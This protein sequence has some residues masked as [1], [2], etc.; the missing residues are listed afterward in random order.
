MKRLLPLFALLLFA[1]C[2]AFSE[3]LP[4][5]S[6]EEEAEEEPPDY[7]YDLFVKDIHSVPDYPRLTEEYK[8]RVQVQRY[9][10]YQPSGYTIWV[11]DGNQT[12]MRQNISDPELLQHFEFEYYA[13]STQPHNMRAEVL[14]LDPEHPEPGENLENNI[15]RKDVKAYPIGYYDIYNWKVNWFYDFV[16][17]QVRQAQAF[18]PQ[19][20]LNVSRIG[21]YVQARVPPSPGSKLFISLHEKPN[22]WGNLGVGEELAR[23]EID[24]TQ[25][26]QDASW[27]W[28]EFNKTELRNDTYWIMLSYESPS[29]AGIEWYRAEGNP[30]GTV[31]DT[32]MLDLGGYGEWEY[33]GFDFAF[34]V[35]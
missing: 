23:G 21:V 3:E 4:L 24:A 9:G 10:R 16:G 35:E 17:I 12:I 26:A 14:S 20:P 13:D 31:Y 29:T 22:N 18:T 34:K 2:C 5:P 11:L 33:K 6:I 28:I 7:S 30:Y 27:Q 1:G 32:Q 8:V 15:M 25:I 19:K